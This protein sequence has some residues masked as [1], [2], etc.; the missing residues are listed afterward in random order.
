[1]EMGLTVASLG[2]SSLGFD[3]DTQ[4]GSQT[5]ATCIVANTKYTFIGRYISNYSTEQPG[6]LDTTELLNIT[7]GFLYVAVIQHALAAGSTLTA[8]VGTSMAQNAINNAKSASVPVGA[9]I[10][11]DI[12]DYNSSS[13]PLD[14]CEAWS[15]TLKSDGTYHP[16]L[17]FGAPGL[18]A[19]QVEQLVNGGYFLASWSGCGAPK[20][21][22]ESIDQGPCDITISATCSGTTY[23]LSADQDTIK[24]NSVGGFVVYE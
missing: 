17:Y 2:V 10:W 18:D 24:V 11:L 21:F 22:G 9:Y 19:S 4:I 8:A 16:A 7:K 12:E 14:Y 20:G 23:S 6:D 15:N 5:E 1:M 13:H 3:T